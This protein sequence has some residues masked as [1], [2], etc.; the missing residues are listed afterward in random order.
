MKKNFMV[1]LAILLIATIVISYFAITTFLGPSE[2]TDVTLDVIT[3]WTGGSEKAAFEAVNDAFMEKYPHITITHSPLPWETFNT[4]MPIW[5]DESP[6]DAFMWW[7]G[8]RTNKIVNQNL[9]LDISDISNDVESEFPEG[10]V[11]E[12]L[13]YNE[14]TYA[15]PLMVN[16]HGVFYSKTVFSQY[17]VDVPETWAELVTACQKIDSDSGGSV[18]PFVAGAKFPWLPDL[19]I[20][21]ILGKTVGAETFKKLCSGEVSWTTS[22]VVEAFEH[23]AELIEYMPS[24]VTELGDTEVAE[25]F[26]AEKVAIEIIGP[27]RSAMLETTGMTEDEYGWFDLPTIKANY[28][29]TIGSAVD[30]LVGSSKTENPEQVKTYLKFWASTEAQEIFSQE[31]NAISASVNVRPNTYSREFMEEVAAKMSGAS[32]FVTEFGLAVE[33]A[34][35]QSD[36]RDIVQEFIQDPS[37]AGWTHV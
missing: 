13:N 19:Q 14:K 17:S 8:A 20:A 33:N 7:G 11:S 23:Y 34:E 31:R 30:V 21:N 10:I 25:E 1:M 2:E 6:P 22:E 29:T 15:V 26:A 4:V 35:L 9:V 32:G 28:A 18:S 16:I 27:W 5:I 24:Y 36:F 12:Y 37:D 3:L